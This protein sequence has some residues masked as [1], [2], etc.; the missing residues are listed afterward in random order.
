MGRE[1]KIISSANGRGMGDG[2]A[3]NDSISSNY[4]VIWSL[5]IHYPLTPVRT[6]TGYLSY[7]VHYLSIHYH[8]DHSLSVC[9]QYYIGSNVCQWYYALHCSAYHIVDVN[10]MSYQAILDDWSLGKLR[11]R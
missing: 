9:M 6:I 5:L 1:A 8:Y 10:I 3:I 11:E 2:L 4:T 7:S